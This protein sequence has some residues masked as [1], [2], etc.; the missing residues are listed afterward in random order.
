[1]K[2][3]SCANYGSPL[4]VMTLQSD[5]KYLTGVSFGGCERERKDKTAAS[6]T[7]YS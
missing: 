7:I 5:G 2:K 4:G 6:K 3:A 1:M